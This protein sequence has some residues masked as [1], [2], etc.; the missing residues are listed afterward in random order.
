M[1]KPIYGTN[2]SAA[3]ISRDAQGNPTGL[4]D[5]ATG[6]AIS[7]GG[8][9]ATTATASAFSSAV[10]AGTLDKTL[11][12]T[13]ST[14]TYSFVYIAGQYFLNVKDNDSI[15]LAIA[16][17]TA[18]V[19]PI[20]QANQGRVGALVIPSGY[21]NMSSTASTITLEPWM[22]V[23]SMG[24]VKIN[25][26]SAT[27]PT[28]WVRNDVTP[29]FNQGNNSTNTASSTT[30]EADF[31]PHNLLDGSNGAFILQSNLPGSSSAIR[32]GNGDGVWGTQWTTNT[33]NTTLFLKFT[34]VHIMRYDNA[35]QF[36]SNNN[37][38][39]RWQN[40]WV[41]NCDKS[42]VT[43][44]A[45]GNINAFEQHSFFEFFSGNINVTHV[46]FNG[47]ANLDNQFAF[48]HSS[49][50][51]CA[52][53]IFTFNTATQAR[54]E[55]TQLRLENFTYI[56]YSAV[57]SPKSSIR[58]QNCT[59]V[60]TNN[61]GAGTYPANCLRKLFVGTFKVMATNTRIQ[62]GAP[63]WNTVVYGKADNQFLA[64]D[65]VSIS[66]VNT[67]ADDPTGD[68]TTN[69]Y[70][71]NQPILNSSVSL[72]SN[73][74]FENGLTNWTT[75]GTGTVSATTTAGEYFTGTAG[76]KVV[77]AAQYASLTSAA[78]RVNPGQR[79]YGDCVARYL[80]TSTTTTLSIIPQ[81]IWYAEDGTTVIRTDTGTQNS[82]Y[83]NWYN[84]KSATQFYRHPTGTGVLTAPAG[85]TLAKFVVNISS[86]TAAGGN[87]TG[88]VYLDNAVVVAL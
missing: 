62:I 1:A 36:T 70:M 30:A 24:Q 42:I 25:H 49:F 37:F 10:I 79:Y 76:V 14:G 16:E 71:R 75:G 43:S 74:G 67:E 35:I 47:G 69:N 40:V 20:A 8:G 52:G 66:M 68:I 39:S 73:W 48:A 54:V 32:Y 19:R 81:V 50:T 78:F 60:P 4:Y 82:T 61:V 17:W 44:T 41:S 15:N 87:V 22:A 38:C 56:G 86:T 80:D 58:M 34:G 51:F 7:T 55:L 26:N 21:Y 18:V 11:T 12:Y 64:D 85:A 9:G 88:T 28:I 29:I 23:K 2:L 63:T 5:P 33:I 13:V 3:G 59:I 77:M 65:T 27:V 45:T 6:S 53:P 31:S 57:A 72:I 46:E 83:Q 84:R